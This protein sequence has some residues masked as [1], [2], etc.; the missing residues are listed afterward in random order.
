MIDYKEF[1][2]A[3][4]PR[5]GG[6]WFIHVTSIMGLGQGQKAKLHEPPPSDATGQN[7]NVSLVRHPCN[8][9]ES[10]F[11]ALKG[12]LVGVPLIDELV[13]SA[14][15]SKDINLFADRVA[16]FHA[17]II[18]EI[19]DSYKPSTVMRLEDLP[20]AAGEFF[21]SL[22]YSR[23]DIQCVLDAPPINCRDHKLTDV[24]MSKRIR[25][26][27]ADSEQSLFDRYDY[28]P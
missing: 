20:W 4:P 16:G 18:T 17:G 10:Y 6:S 21:M 1:R 13:H 28:Q 25:K 24:K 23:R 12:G 14:R 5:T 8:W 15:D 3:S 27:V 7:L 19:F 9:L 11:Y 2:F 26:L 22:G